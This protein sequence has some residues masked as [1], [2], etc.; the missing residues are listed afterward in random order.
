MN[1]YIGSLKQLQEQI[2]IVSDKALIDLINGIQVSHDLINYGNNQGVLGRLW[3]LLTGSDFQKQSLLNQN[4]VVGQKTLFQ[5]ALELTHSQDV[6]QVALAVTQEKLLEAR[7]AIR[8]QQQRL[9]GQ[10]KAVEILFSELEVLR[11]Q[12]DERF[13]Q[14]DLRITKLEV[15]NAID[16]IVKAWNNGRTYKNLGWA[17]QVV[18]LAR[19]VFSNFV[20]TYELESG[21]RDTFRQRLI[22][23]IIDSPLS[24]EIPDPDKTPANP[25]CS[26]E[27]ILRKSRSEMA[28]DDHTLELASA[29]LEVRSVPQQR[30]VKTPLLFTIGTALELAI[31]PSDIRP[32]KPDQCAI[33]LCRAYIQPINDITDRKQF[34]ETIV[35]ETANDCMAMMAN[36]PIITN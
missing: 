7:E 25:F 27:D 32:K 5:W 24:Q 2:P 4:Q 28:S 14:H 3:G 34:V 12:V 15:R 1:K 9:D 20:T 11:S 21:D 23:E 30:L 16:D 29:L 10:E 31:L 13:I 36:R 22:N 18:F 33:E 26:L 17:V 8:R 6:S 19:E 35:E